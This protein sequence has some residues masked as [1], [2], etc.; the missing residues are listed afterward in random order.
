MQY[1]QVNDSGGQLCFGSVGSL[2]KRQ[3]P[4][5]G[6]GHRILTSM[7]GS[8]PGLSGQNCPYASTWVVTSI[9]D[10]L[11]PDAISTTNINSDHNPSTCLC[12][13]LPKISS[14]EVEVN[15][16]GVVFLFPW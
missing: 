12:T 9:I 14:S 3:K 15:D 16:R 1:V 7:F 13:L 6:S 10:K 8:F 5:T 11:L 4:V 2:W